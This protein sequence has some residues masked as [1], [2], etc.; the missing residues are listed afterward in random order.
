MCTRSII[1]YRC[2]HQVS[3]GNTRCYREDCTGPKEE[4][5][6]DTEDCPQCE[7]NSRVHSARWCPMGCACKCVVM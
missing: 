7:G 5:A 2:K 3:R 6:Y 4:I 1:E